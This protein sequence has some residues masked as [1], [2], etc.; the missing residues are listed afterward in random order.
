MTSSRRWRHALGG[1]A[2]MERRLRM[3]G[4]ANEKSDEPYSMQRGVRFQKANGAMSNDA[5]PVDPLD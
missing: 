3:V 2:M 1:S 4:M 5:H